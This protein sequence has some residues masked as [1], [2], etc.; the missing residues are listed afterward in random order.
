MEK[1]IAKKQ[2]KAAWDLITEEIERDIESKEDLKEL[3]LFVLN[4]YW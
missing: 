4:T 1:L 2:Y 3:F